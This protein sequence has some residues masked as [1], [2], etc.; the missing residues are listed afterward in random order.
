MEVEAMA[1]MDE[2]LGASEIFW[3][4]LRITLGVLKVWN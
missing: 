4:D 1:C 2:R 3:E